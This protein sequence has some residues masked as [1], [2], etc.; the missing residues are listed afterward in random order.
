MPMQGR[1]LWRVAL[2]AKGK[3]TMEHQYRLILSAKSEIVGGNRHD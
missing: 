3:A 1:W 2:P